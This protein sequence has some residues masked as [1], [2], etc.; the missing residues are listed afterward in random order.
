MK[1]SISGNKE[2]KERG[3]AGDLSR[4]RRV[5]CRLRRGVRI[6]REQLQCRSAV[7]RQILFRQ[8]TA[9]RF[10]YRA[11]RHDRHFLFALYQTQKN[12]AARADRIARSACPRL[13]SGGRQK[14][15]RCD[16]LDR[17]RVV[18]DSAFRNRK[19]RSDFIY[20]GLFCQRSRAHALV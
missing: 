6:C 17:V 11:C 15:L 18:Y 10:L 8:E 20:R 14:Q 1:K 3:G 12:R 19:I 13:Y 4:R 9:H 2:K 5:A 16:A 7:R